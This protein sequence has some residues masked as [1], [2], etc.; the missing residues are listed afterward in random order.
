MAKII[1]VDDIS[2]IAMLF[3]EI[4]KG[5]GLEAVP[6]VGG[7]KAIEWIWEIAEKPDL[8]IV[9]L[10]MPPYDAL[11][12]IK[13]ARDRFGSDMPAIITS[14]GFIKHNEEKCRTVTPYLIQLP[15]TG[16]D[17]RKFVREVL[18]ETQSAPTPI[19]T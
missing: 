17:F 19:Q 11:E 8:M 4:L 10:D 7:A 1:I 6:I 9:N 12:I 5:D 2:D 3:A 13:Q 15:I 18:R 16:L 14:G